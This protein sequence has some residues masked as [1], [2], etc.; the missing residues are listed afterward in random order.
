MRPPDRYHSGALLQKR[1][2]L[3]QCVGLTV[4]PNFAMFLDYERKQ[5]DTSVGVTFPQKRS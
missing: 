2:F 3:R 5:R 1:A 4:E